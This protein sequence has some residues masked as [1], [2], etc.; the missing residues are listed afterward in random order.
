MTLGGMVA[1]RWIM[2]PQIKI[3]RLNAAILHHTG[4][5]KAHNYPHGVL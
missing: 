3:E 5:V 2:G 1:G 4:V